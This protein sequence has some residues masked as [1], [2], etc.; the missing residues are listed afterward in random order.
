MKLWLEAEEEFESFFQGK[1]KFVFKFHDTRMAM[2]ILKTKKVKTTEHPSDY[3]VTD[4]GLMYYAEV[5][6]TNDKVS[7]P[8]GNIQKGQWKAATRQV[9][10]GG[11]YFFFVRSEAWKTWYKVPAQVLLEH[12]KVRQSI[13]WSEL[14]DYKWSNV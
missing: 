2:G 1:Q 13:K 7:L 8:F 14:S 9:A 4:N 6:S 5:K 3:I 12:S 10:A 11:L